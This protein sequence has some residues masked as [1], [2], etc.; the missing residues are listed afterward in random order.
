MSKETEHG[1]PREEEVLAARR[2]S[3]ERIRKAGKEPFALTFDPDTTAAQ[4]VAEFPEGRLAPGAESGRRAKVA[5]RVVLARRHGKLTFLVI[6]DRTGDLQ[7][8]CDEQTMGAASYGLLEETDLGD[9]I[10]A[11]GIAVRTKRGELS[12]KTDAVVMLTKALRPLP[13]KWHGLKDPDLQQRR[14]YVHLIV[15][16]AP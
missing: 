9:L 7:L 5:G 16:E 10:G 12:V 2:Q 4:L 14:R 8:L 1:S 6:R 11:E 3:L 13:E 15:D